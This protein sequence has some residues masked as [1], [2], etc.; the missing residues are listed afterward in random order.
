MMGLG[1]EAKSEGNVLGARGSGDDPRP[2]YKQIRAPSPG[3]APL[4]TVTDTWGLGGG[5]G[6]CLSAWSGDVDLGGEGS[7]GR[8]Y[9]GFVIR[10]VSS[11]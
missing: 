6:S 8:N 2:A 1:T 11:L 5:G 9:R 3:G 10:K 4:D 7:L